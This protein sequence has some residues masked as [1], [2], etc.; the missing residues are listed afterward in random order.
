MRAIDFH[1][2]SKKLYAAAQVEPG[3]HIVLL[4]IRKD[5][6][7]SKSPFGCPYAVLTHRSYTDG[8]VESSF[9]DGRY[10]ADYIKALEVFAERVRTFASR[11]RI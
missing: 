4:D 9:E 6:S 10:Y 2:E 11:A 7:E 8:V 3:L 5:P 1:G